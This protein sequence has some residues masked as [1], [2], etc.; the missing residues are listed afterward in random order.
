[1]KKSPVLINTQ[2]AL[3]FK[4]GIERP[5]LIYND[6][7]TQMGG[8]FSLPPQII[9]LPNESQFDQVPLIQMTSKNSVYSLNIAKK[10][11]DFFISGEGLEAFESKKGL[12]KEKS[13]I[14]L[15]FFKEHSE[16]K[17]MGFVTRFFIEDID[18]VSNIKSLISPDFINIHKKD[19]EELETFDAYVRFASKSKF[20]SIDILNHSFIDK[21]NV[22]ITNERKEGVLITRDFYTSPNDDHSKIINEK[23]LID[24]IEYGSELFKINEISKLIWQID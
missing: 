23:F 20:K 8:I 2:I 14:F 13:S 6:L 24:F 4:D 10:R 19:G 21:G 12:L 9:P 3:F 11:A 22:T 1:M 7:N 17:R 18:P 16:I 5:D 15:N